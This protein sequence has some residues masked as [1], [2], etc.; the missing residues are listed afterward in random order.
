MDTD[1][2]MR[3]FALVS[4]C[5]VG[6]WYTR[7]NNH[8]LI[9]YAP[10]G[11][12]ALAF[13]YDMDFAFTQS[14][15]APVWGD[16]GL[17]RIIQLVP[18]R[19]AF[20]T[21]LLDLRERAFSQAYMNRWLGHYGRLCGQ[22]F[23]SIGPAIE[24]RWNFIQRSIPPRV[25]FAISTNEGADFAT[26]EAS[27]ILEGSGWVDVRSVLLASRE[28]FLELEWPQ[29]TR[30]RTRVDLGSGAN[31]L[32]LIALGLDDRVLAA[33]A[34]RVTA[35]AGIFLRGDMTRD[36]SLNVTDAIAILRHLFQGAPAPCADAGDA[37]DN[38]ALNLTDAIY[39]LEYLF[40]RGPAP[41]APY[42]AR[43]VDSGGPLDCAEGLAGG[44]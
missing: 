4:L 35:P 10:P 11:G 7:G 1:Q 15:D 3:A 23:T 28:E 9:I 44:A 33:D 40:R 18:N 19:R 13:P 17:A 42:P 29:L 20:Y 26:E 5:G 16:Q 22:D 24:A 6:D 27:V 36:G 30:W 34:I 38:E 25:E 2:W 43:G 12:K 37:D 31:E 14:A 8:N 21:H 39:V 41:A 32:E